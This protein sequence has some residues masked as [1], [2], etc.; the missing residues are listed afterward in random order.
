MPR[1]FN[2]SNLF[3]K[4]MGVVFDLAVLNILTLVCSI[5][6]V[7]AGASFTAM[8]YVLWHMVR[9]EETY[10][11]RQFFEAFTRNFRQATLFWL[12]CLPF[13]ALVWL[14]VLVIQELPAENRWLLFATLAVAAL[15]ATAITEMYFVL[16]SRY[17]NRTWTQLKNAALLSLGY[18]PRTIA[19]MLVLATFAAIYILFST[20]LIPLLIFL[21][22][23]LPQ[24]CCAW[25]YNPIL[26]HLDERN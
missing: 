13:I 2:Q 17:E 16:L 20:Y 25:L 8:H 1:L 22:L 21:G 5:P 12:G 23:T 18:F 3:F 24:Y 19:M 11:A 4:V 15:V 26:V 6:I 10:I 7:T 14:N 9:G